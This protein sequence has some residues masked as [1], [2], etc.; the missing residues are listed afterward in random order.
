MLRQCIVHMLGLLALANAANFSE[1]NLKEDNSPE[2]FA[3][4][5]Y[6]ALRLTTFTVQTLKELVDDIA[7]CNKLNDKFDLH[8]ENITMAWHK[9]EYEDDALVAMMPCNGLLVNVSILENVH[10]G[11]LQMTNVRPWSLLPKCTHAFLHKEAESALH[12]T[13]PANK[14]SKSTLF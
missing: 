7:E 13:T 11:A 3:I 10:T 2:E 4:S 8:C 12:A 9:R 1:A 5:S 6:M 14:F